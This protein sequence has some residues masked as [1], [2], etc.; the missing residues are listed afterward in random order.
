VAFEELSVFLLK[1]FLAVVFA[2]IGNVLADGFDIGF[3][4]GE[5]TIASLLGECRE[6]RTLGFNPFG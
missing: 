3:R 2:L 4:N 6:F 1:G 5:G